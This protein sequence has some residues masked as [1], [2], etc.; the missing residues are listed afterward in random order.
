M[1]G[2]QRGLNMEALKQSPKP[3]FGDDYWKQLLERV[4]FFE[5]NRA[6]FVQAVNAM[7]DHA[8]YVDNARYGEH[9]I[10]LMRELLGDNI[11]VW[12][13][14]IADQAY[15]LEDLRD[16]VRAEAARQQARRARDTEPA[17]ARPN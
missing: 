15:A 7:N 13:T 5:R 17:A 12:A 10:P 6:Q 16:R 11:S 2:S 8:R 4:T 14:F 9:L 1:P 3:P